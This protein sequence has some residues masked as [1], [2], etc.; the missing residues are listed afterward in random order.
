MSIV[1]PIQQEPSAEIRTSQSPF[2]QR[3]SRSCRNL[4]SRGGWLIYLAALMVI[5][6]VIGLLATAHTYYH[7]MGGPGWLKSKRERVEV[8]HTY[9][10]QSIPEPQICL[11]SRRFAF[12]KGDVSPLYINGRSPANVPYYTCGDQQNSCEAYGHPVSGSALPA[13]SVINV[14]LLSCRKSAVRFE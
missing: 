7:E 1:T 11:P 2:S 13:H 10:R 8:E 14:F 4:L 6:I 3:R 5:I 12:E 9:P